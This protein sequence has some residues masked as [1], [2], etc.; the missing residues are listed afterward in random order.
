ML[1]LVA[2]RALRTVATA[3]E[4]WA[5]GRWPLASGFLG[6]RGVDC[7]GGSYIYTNP[8]KTAVT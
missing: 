4:A 7:L 2:P 8:L 1:G 5:A 6:L 3:L